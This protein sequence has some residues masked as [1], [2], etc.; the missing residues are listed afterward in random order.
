MIRAIIESRT[1]ARTHAR[2][3][4]PAHSHAPTHARFG[5][6]F[7]TL[8]AACLHAH[9]QTTRTRIED[10]AILLAAQWGR[11]VL[12]AHANLQ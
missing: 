6:H 8:A 12:R 1:H 3:H 10:R 4:A 11:R 2:N 9:A 7:P 5:F